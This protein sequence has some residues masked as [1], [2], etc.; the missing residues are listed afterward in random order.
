MRIKNWFSCAYRG[1]SVPIISSCLP[2]LQRAI[3]LQIANEPTAN[4]KPARGHSWPI[5]QFRFSTRSRYFA[6]HYRRRT[7]RCVVLITNYTRAAWLACVEWYL[8]AAIRWCYSEFND[9]TGHYASVKWQSSERVRTVPYTHTRIHVWF[10]VILK[11][12]STLT[13]CCHEMAR[14]C[15]K[16]DKNLESSIAIHCCPTFEMIASQLFTSARKNRAVN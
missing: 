4:I 9:S 7:A 6:K 3:S 1:P 10:D 2:V 13:N 15:A 5:R 14:M 11:Q 16:R 8:Q 12:L